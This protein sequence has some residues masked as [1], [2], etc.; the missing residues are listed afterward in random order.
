MLT[1]KGILPFG[2]EIDG[3]RHREFE[4]RQQLHG[5]L[6][7]AA[8]EERAMQNEAYFATAIMARRLVRLG[9]L[10]RERITTALLLLLVQEDYNAIILAAQRLENR[11]VT[12]RDQNAAATSD[13]AGADEARV[14]AG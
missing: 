12:F 2:V 10:P 13:D 11:V 14:P 8:G 7:D 3:R 5:D 6:V 1:E 4:L 9:D